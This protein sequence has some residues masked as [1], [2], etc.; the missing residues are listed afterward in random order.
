M[1]LE[2][3]QGYQAGLAGCAIDAQQSTPW[4]FGI[5]QG[6][7][8]RNRRALR[9]CVAVA[10][11]ETPPPRWV[12]FEYDVPVVDETSVTDPVVVDGDPTYL[13][14]ALK[15]ADDQHWPSRRFGY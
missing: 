9:A 6:K 4:H 8:D 3:S 11:A 14:E 12:V 1:S 15:Q 10:Q 7:K 2:W 13:Q 5:D